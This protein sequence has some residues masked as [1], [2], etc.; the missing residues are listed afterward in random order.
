MSSDQ[1]MTPLAD[2]TDYLYCPACKIHVACTRIEAGGW[3]VN[4]PGCVGECGLCKCYLRS[5]CFGSREEFPPFP[6]GRR[7]PDEAADGDDQGES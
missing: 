3:E 6:P 5:Y 1:P 2:D 7:Y 4:C